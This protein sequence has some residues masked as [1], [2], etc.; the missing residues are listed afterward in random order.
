MTITMRPA[1]P[2]GWVFTFPGTLTNRSQTGPVTGET[3][4]ATVTV[5]NA[6]ARAGNH[7]VQVYGRPNDAGDDFPARVLLG[8]APVALEAGESIRVTV[9]ASV[10]PLQRWTAK[11]FVP[12]AASAVIEASGYSGD[13]GTATAARPV[14][15]DS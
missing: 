9:A 13:P 12:A 3:F 6:G 5:T 7:V 4:E 1:P 2:S 11:G 15:L 14:T 8:F 10:R